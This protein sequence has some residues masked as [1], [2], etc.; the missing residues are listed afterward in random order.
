MSIEIK[1]ATRRDLCYT[2][3]NAIDLDKRELLGS[4]PRNMTEVG[5]L[6]WDALCNHGGL[7]KIV[8]VDD[9]PE[10]AYGFTPYSVLQP[11]LFSGWAWGS[12]KRDLCMIE[13]SRWARK[14]L[15][16]E[17]DRMGCTRIEA[18]SLAEHHEAHRWLEWM[19]FKKDCDLPGWGREGENFVQYSWVRAEFPGFSKWGSVRRIK[20]DRH[21]HGLPA[22]IL[23]SASAPT[24]LD[25]RRRIA[26]KSA[27]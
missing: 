7:G 11:W 17:L 26:R 21:V 6:T 18:R 14:H 27:G 9:N 15:V 13:I 12:D 3:A 4:G 16:P 1:E 10:F 2:A 20:G 24:A 25:R 8:W 23:P 5:W 22:T 19:A